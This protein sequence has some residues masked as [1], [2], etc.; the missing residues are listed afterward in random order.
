MVLRGSEQIDGPKHTSWGGKLPSLGIKK[1]PNLS[2]PC[3]HGDA[4]K[5]DTTCSEWRKPEVNISSYTGWRLFAKSKSEQYR[6]FLQ[7]CYGMVCVERNRKDHL[8]PILLPQTE[9][10]HDAKP[11]PYLLTLQCYKNITKYFLCCPCRFICYNTAIKPIALGK[12]ERS[13]L[14][15]QLIFLYTAYQLK[16]ARFIPPDKPFCD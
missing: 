1:P 13:S 4:N 3:R 2:H 9:T 6:D 11:L 7:Y 5:A 8:V 16:P 10:R 12:G 14:Q 15:A